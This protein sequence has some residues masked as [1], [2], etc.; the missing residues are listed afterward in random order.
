MKS[1]FKL[2]IVMMINYSLVFSAYG[3]VELNERAEFES[4]DFVT[5]TKEI[6]KK[7][8]DQR[9]KLVNKFFDK[10]IKKA[11]R[12]N[13][14]LSESRK[15]LEKKMNRSFKKVQKSERKLRNKQARA[16]VNRKLS[17]LSAN[18]SANEVALSLSSFANKTEFDQNKKQLIDMLEVAGSEVIFL[19]QM[20]DQF[21][22]S[23]ASN[24]LI[25]GRNIASDPA[26]TEF[27]ISISVIAGLSVWGVIALFSSAGAIMAIVGTLGIGIVAVVLGFVALARGL[28]HR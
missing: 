22:S 3:N 24:N 7:T 25:S 10:K 19:E 18:V 6:N 27:F 16:I 28:S 21:L 11:K 17:K 23:F 13:K 5:I 1:L 8:Q 4:Y 9:L 26:T 2:Q 15:D 20:K 14:S 12:K